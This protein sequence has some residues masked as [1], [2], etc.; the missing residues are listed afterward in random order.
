MIADS[1][2][3]PERGRFPNIGYLVPCD[4]TADYRMPSGKLVLSGRSS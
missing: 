4:N 3:S 2:G 1:N